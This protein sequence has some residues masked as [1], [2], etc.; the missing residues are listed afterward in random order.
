M[1]LVASGGCEGERDAQT[2]CVTEAVTTES[3]LRYE[4]RVCGSGTQAERGDIVTVEYVASLA[5]GAVVDSSTRRGKPFAFPL[6]AGHVIPGWE[7]GIPGMRVGGIREL[8]VPPELAYG[9]S[10]VFSTVPPSA[11]LIFEVELLRVDDSG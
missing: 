7:Q 11:T 8:V 2:G 4:D 9:R 3:G 6:G 1:A 10:G 5:T